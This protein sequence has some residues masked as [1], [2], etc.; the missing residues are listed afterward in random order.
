MKLLKKKIKVILEKTRTGF[1]AYAAD[2]DIPVG[3][4]G[5]SISELKDNILEALNL[6]YEEKGYM[7]RE[8]NISIEIDLQQFFQYYKVLNG[9]FL[10]EKI[11]MNPTLLSQYVQGRKKPS[12]QQSEKI[13]NGIQQIG[14][15]LAELRLINN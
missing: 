4:T 10:A 7:I 13:I 12:Q 8:N 6:Y 15:E 14:R 3:T 2:D 9:K 5:K 11:G 1:S